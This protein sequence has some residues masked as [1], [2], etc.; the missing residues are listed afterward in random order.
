MLANPVSF[1]GLAKLWQ[2]QMALY[3]AAKG[4]DV[5]IARVF[6]TIGSGMSAQLSLGAFM[7]QIRNTL[8]Q[9]YP[10][11][12]KV[13]NVQSKRDFLDI[14]DVCRG[15]LALAKYGR[16]GEIYNVCSG[17]SRSIGEILDM[18][19]K[20]SKMELEIICD[21]DR[22]RQNDADNIYGSNVKIKEHT[23]WQPQ[24]GIGESIKRL[25]FFD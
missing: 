23:G 17:C 16:T 19:M 15:L 20:A 25:M 14:E 1:Y 24:I 2:S 5:I 6:N 18:M 21:K 22:L 9:D 4:L 3:Y 8:K 12:L 10:A 7:Q 11:Q 13:G